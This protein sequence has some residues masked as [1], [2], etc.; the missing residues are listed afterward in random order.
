MGICAQLGRHV[1]PPSL[2]P[3]DFHAALAEACG[4][5]TLPR[6]FMATRRS[7]WQH[8]KDKSLEEE[9]ALL[10]ARY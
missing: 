8:L 4:S 3:A 9:A 10:Y 6:A 1:L 7:E 2:S 5:K